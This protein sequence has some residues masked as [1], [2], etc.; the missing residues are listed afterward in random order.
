MKD[1]YSNEFIDYLKRFE[2][3]NPNAYW[4]EGEYW[5]KD[6]KEKKYTIGYGTTTYSNG[7]KVKE[8]DQITEEEA[9]NLMHQ[10][11][12]SKVEPLKKYITNWDKLPQ[13]VKE[14]LFSIV[15]RGGS[16]DKSK[17]FA[18]A[19]NAA[20]DDGWMTTEE[21]Q[22][23]L[24]EMS[25]NKKGN[26]QDRMYRNAALLGGLY[27]YADNI[28]INHATTQRSPYKNFNNN[29][30]YP[31]NRWN[32]RWQDKQHLNNSNANF[33]QRLKDPNRETINLGNGSVGTH[34]MANTNINGQEVMFPTIQELP[35]YPWWNFLHIGKPST[36]LV[37]FEDTQKALDSAIQNNDTVHIQDPWT[38]EHYKQFF[39]MKQGG[40]INYLN[41]FK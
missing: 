35:S 12:Q 21:Y 23:V 27:D 41:H 6:K 37:K 24:S 39:V 2:G 3:F 4:I 15:Y 9:T 36:K 25:F 32:I 29:V 14:G 31:G 10:Y 38:A 1:Q 13:Q 8:G 30:F 26:L 19:L 11:L 18:D 34:L 40:R 5:D 16:L 17:D 33:V 28:S 22:K 20:Y 7:V